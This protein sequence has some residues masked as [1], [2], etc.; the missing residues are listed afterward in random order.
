[1]DGR[2]R[3]NGTGLANLPGRKQVLHGDHGRRNRARIGLVGGTALFLY[4]C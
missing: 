3:R 1:M 2:A 4:W